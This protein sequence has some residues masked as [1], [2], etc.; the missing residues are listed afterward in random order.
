[1]F[2]WTY[3]AS[4]WLIRLVMMPVVLRHRRPSASLAWLMIIFFL[5]WV[6]LFMYL[7]I[8][9]QR[10][11]R[12]RARRSAQAH[13]M[14]TQLSRLALRSPHIVHP[15]VNPRLHGLVAVGERVGDAPILGGNAVELIGNTDA[16]IERL[17]A[18]IDGAA[19]SV[20]ILV[21]IFESD[22]TG[23]RV[24]DALTRAAQRGVKCR[25]LVDDV[26]SARMLRRIAPGLRQ[27]GVEVLRLLPASWWRFPLA[28]MDLRNHR[29]LYVIDGRI[30]YAGSQNIVDADYGHK[31]IGAWR[32]L[33]MRITGPVVMQC[34]QV[35]LEDWYSETGVALDE[36]ELFPTPEPVGSTCVQIVPSGPDRPNEQMRDV[37]LAAIQEAEHRIIITSPYLSPDETI[38]AA[39]RVAVLRNVRVDIVIPSRGNHPIVAAAG[40]S[41]ARD[42]AMAGV[43][44]HLHNGGLLHAKSMSVDESFA[45]IG[46]SNFDVRSF[47]LNFEVNVLI[48]DRASAL[49][50]VRQQESYIAESQQIDQEWLAARRGLILLWDDLCRLGSPLL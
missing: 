9:G 13:R 37:L 4:E 41:F 44:V 30:A 48:Y 42:L 23:R 15:E 2:G 36:N 18:D 32:D 10:L 35:V 16:L 20:N 29:K 6:G 34:Q 26:G 47:E 25:V 33:M 31:R 50:L 38:V 28:R 5:P 43:H 12:R 49:K 17:I 7:L 24:A 45:M 8:G 11:G 40:W 21:Y 46:S 27:A 14:V 22:D 39:L 19:N 1:M 3:L